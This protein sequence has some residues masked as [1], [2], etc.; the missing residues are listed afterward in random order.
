MV[1]PLNIVIIAS[2]KRIVQSALEKYDFIRRFGSDPELPPL[3][4]EDRMLADKD[5][6]IFDTTRKFPEGKFKWDNFEDISEKGEIR[7]FSESIEESWKDP[8]NVN[9]GKKSTVY[10]AGTYSGA[11]HSKIDAGKNS[12][13]GSG[14]KTTKPLPLTNS[15]K[16]IPAK[17]GSGTKIEDNDDAG[18][19]V[20]MEIGG[21]AETEKAYEKATSLG[22]CSHYDMV[23][24]IGD[25]IG[26]TEEEIQKMNPIE[27]ANLLGRTHFN[28]GYATSRIDTKNEISSIRGK[29]RELLSKLEKSQEK[30]TRAQN[31]VWE[32]KA[33]IQVLL[34]LCKDNYTLDSKNIDRV[35]DG[36][37]DLNPERKRDV[38]RAARE[39]L[40]SKDTQ[41][42]VSEL[43]D[44]FRHVEKK[45]VEG[46]QG[47][48]EQAP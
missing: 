43:V 17:A 26:K 44:K 10:G 35:I 24:E 7:G 5:F 36:F 8:K 33:V 38:V 15:I 47:K 12:R 30:K 1:G 41:K 45:K 4:T 22:V 46:Q 48:R 13:A 29:G 42:L 2:E 39:V 32:Y 16:A 27:L 21:K 23:K 6:R 25:A 31:H 40:D 20:E 3:H 9:P 11:N 14:A 37:P 18:I 19:L 28:L 34:A